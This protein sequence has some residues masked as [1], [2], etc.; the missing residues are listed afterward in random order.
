MERVT[1]AAGRRTWSYDIKHLEGRYLPWTTSGRRQKGGCGPV[2]VNGKGKGQ[3]GSARPAKGQ[4]PVREYKLEGEVLPLAKLLIPLLIPILFLLT[5]VPT[6]FLLESPGPSFD[7]QEDLAVK[8]TETHP[9]QGEFMLTAV[10][11]QESRLFYHLLTLFG[12]GYET[13]KV[14]DYLGEDL[15]VE[16]QE[17][18]DELLTWLSQDAA[19]V[20]GL[21]ESGKEVEVSGSGALV[22]AIAE[23]Y[24]ADG[25]LHPGEVIVSVNGEPVE[26]GAEMS[27]LIGSTPEGGEV[28]LGVKAVDREALKAWEDGRGERPDLSRLLEDEAREVELQPVWEPELNRALIGVSTRDY[29]TFSSEISVEWDLET[30]KGP[31]AGLMMTLSLLNSLTPEDL[32]GGM[33]VAGT[34]EI[35]LDGRVGPIGGLTMKVKAAER[36]GAKVFIYPLDNQD[37]LE[38]FSARLELYGV[39]SLEEAL[40]VLRGLD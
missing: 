29:F 36:E 8:G 24:P 11:L 22:V 6:G 18:V 16:E 28:T 38:G 7:L 25:A 30:V 26:D 3:E 32:T 14:R 5:A 21:R 34:G 39:G 37:E 35:L 10:S 23:G 1:A 12:D 2:M 27:E 20:V 33:K 15:N 31:S 9:S 17:M 13:V 19:T 40:E 4:A